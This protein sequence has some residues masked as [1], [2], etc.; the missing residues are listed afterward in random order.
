MAALYSIRVGNLPLALPRPRRSLRVQTSNKQR[1]C[2]SPT[3]LSGP[4]PGPG[5]GPKPEPACTPAKKRS[6]SKKGVRFSDP[7]PALTSAED[8]L[9]TTGLTPM[10]HRACLSSSRKSR[11]HSTPSRLFQASSRSGIPDP[12][13]GESPFSGEVRFLP[14]RQVLDGRVKR[15]IRRNGLSEEMNTICEERRQRGQKARAE[16]ERLK[17]E[18]AEKDEEIARLHDETAVLDT[19]RVWNLEQQVA[20]L[21]KELASRSGVEQASSSPNY[22]FT[23]FPSTPFTDE[24]AELGMDID[25]DDDDDDDDDADDAD[26]GEATM[27]ELACS[28]PTRRMHTSFPTPPATSPEPAEIPSPCRRIVAARLDTGIQASF[29][30]PE[31]RQLEQERE[32]LQLEVRKLTSTLESYSSLTSRLSDKLAP[33]ST[34]TSAEEPSS[35]TPKLDIEAQLTTVLQTLSDRTAALAELNTTLKTLG[36][37]GSDAFEVIESLRNSFRAA[38]LELEY[39]TPGEI[40]LPLT[41]AGAEVLDLLLTQLRALAKKNRETDESIDEHRS[42]QLSLRQQLTARVDAMDLLSTKLAT[43]E[44]DA[45]QKD[46]RI[47]DLERSI[48]RLG[49]SIRAYTRDLAELEA[50]AGKLSGELGAS[51]AAA[52][53]LAARL[54]ALQDQLAAL[55]AAHR[56]EVAALVRAHGTHLSQRDARVAAL[57]FEVDRVGAALVEALGAVQRGRVENGRLVREKQAVLDGAEVERRR[58]EGVRRELERVA[59]LL[60]PVV[61]PGLQVADGRKREAS[62]DGEREV[63][64]SSAAEEAIRSAA[65]V[66][67]EGQEECKEGR[68]RKRRRY[69]S[70]LGMLDEGDADGISSDV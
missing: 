24:F 70:G 39:L 64:V 26:F 14:L 52:D 46:A 8:E 6:G 62:E 33:L 40:T 11:R 45:Q 41:S 48:D 22:K 21:K 9:L 53:V 66:L 20:A 13:L 25:D 29:P 60:A 1:R 56:A 63:V 28:T 34:H 4:G 44:R 67:V 59:R 5:P 16:I 2:H 12:Y 68:G 65:P 37:S 61:G 35:S 69:D 10:I 7:G 18:L 17:E 30:D 54:A 32:S 3:A 55:C 23:G 43:A 57:R 36:F 15:R 58:V 42:L 50:L 47:T 27:A 19:D 51:R 31:I 49:D 38:R